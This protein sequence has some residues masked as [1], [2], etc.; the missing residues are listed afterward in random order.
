MADAIQCDLTYPGLDNWQGVNI[1]RSLGVVPDQLRVRFTPNQNAQGQM[2]APA[3]F[4]PLLFRYWGPGIGERRLL[5]P[6]CQLDRV[7]VISTEGGYVFE[8]TLLDP[9]WKWAYGTISGE[10]NVPDPKGDILKG[11][12]KTPQELAKL[13]LE[14]MFNLPPDQDTQRKGS[15]RRAARLSKASALPYDV[16]QLPNDSRPRTEWDDENPARLLDRLADSLGC[17]VVYK[18]NGT[19]KLERAGVGNFLVD[20]DD[21][22]DLN[23]T[24]DP[25]EVPDTVMVVGPEKRFEVILPLQPVALDTDGTFKNP[26]LVSYVPTSDH[27]FFPR[28]Q[29]W[30]DG[31]D[32]LT[33]PLNLA[34]AKASVF[35]CFRLAVDNQNSNNIDSLVS[36]DL[37][38]YFGEDEDPLAL[39]TNNFQ[40]DL[41][42]FGWVEDLW[43]ILPVSGTLV[44]FGF[45]PLKR[46]YS[47]KPG[48]IF[49][50]FQ[51]FDATG[52]PSGDANNVISLGFPQPLIEQDELPKDI[53]WSLD[54][55]TGIVTLG[56]PLI[57]WGRPKTGANGV[58]AVPYL[59]PVLWMR[60]TVSVR[61]KKT[62]AWEKYRRERKLGNRGTGP[63]IIRR[64]DLQHNTILSY[65]GFDADFNPKP[66]LKDGPIGDPDEAESV[67]IATN[68]KKLDQLA[69]KQLDA[70]I[71][72]YSGTRPHVVSYRGLKFVE[73]DGAIRQVMIQ[74]GDDGFVETMASRDDE[75]LG[76]DL[77]LSE[78]QQIGFTLDQFNKGLDTKWAQERFFRQIRKEQQ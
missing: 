49:G 50:V 3:S 14:A 58:E 22:T 13:L 54:P 70:T 60:L 53:D 67:G 7:T 9:R 15:K 65:E 38:E 18:W 66:K 46:D 36:V 31:V 61:D 34:L 29:G 57:R 8:A 24:C 28:R 30:L 12:E 19:V 78:K 56:A 77:R 71:A 11:T 23:L 5:M 73:C 59:F 48:K 45:D 63:R 17:V 25:K 20:D 40:L 52:K 64:D 33:D 72:S 74:A 6:D 35:R 10:Y 2:Q 32:V 75:A 41:P 44:S 43:Q 1:M 68:E 26:Y 62:R 76:T 4:G 39:T 69:D 47:N 21:V 55:D 42:G 27:S 51:A 37:A 16:S